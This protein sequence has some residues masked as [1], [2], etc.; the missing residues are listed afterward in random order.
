MPNLWL[1]TSRISCLIQLQHVQHFNGI[2]RLSWNF[3]S[4][5]SAVAFQWGKFALYQVERPSSASQEHGTE[6]FSMH[7]LLDIWS[8]SGRQ[9]WEFRVLP[10]YTL[11]R[12]FL[13]YGHSWAALG[14]QQVRVSR[15][16]NRQFARYRMKLLG[17]FL[18]RAFWLFSSILR[19]QQIW[20]HVIWD[21]TPSSLS[22]FFYITYCS[23]C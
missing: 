10:S 13:A 3:Y 20:Q 18:W 4:A 15:E 2:R 9:S 17:F 7:C 12:Q 23:D 8:E 5:C 21:L 22:E 1:K 6:S 16:K 11:W 14:C 19:T